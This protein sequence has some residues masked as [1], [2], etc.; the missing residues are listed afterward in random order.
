MIIPS[1]AIAQ[2]D[3][4]VSEIETVTVQETESREVRKAATILKHVASAFP[5]DDL[6]GK[7]VTRGEFVKY[8]AQAFCLDY[9]TTTSG[10]FADVDEKNEA[11]NE[12]NNALANGWISEA[13]RF[14]PNSAISFDEAIKITICAAN[15]EIA[16]NND[17]GFPYGYIRIAQRLKITQNIKRGI[18]DS[19]TA[20]D[21]ALIIYRALKT[22]DVISMS[23]GQKV[24]YRERENNYLYSLHG[25]TEISGTVTSTDVT[26]LY[27]GIDEA[28]EGYIEIDDV[29]YAF[30]GDATGLIGLECTVYY[31]EENK[32][33][34][35]VEAIVPEKVE[36][37]VVD[38]DDFIRSA[39]SEIYY[40]DND[41]EK[42]QIIN[43][44]I[45]N[46][47][48]IESFEQVK[49]ILENGEM[50]FVDT[51]GDGKSNLLFIENY[52]YM[53]VDNV[54]AVEM[55]VGDRN[56]KNNPLFLK[57][58]N[59]DLAIRYAINDE[60]SNEA[61]DIYDLAK[62]DII[63][64]KESLDGMRIEIVICNTGGVS[65]NVTAINPSK[66]TISI[67]G[68]AHK[69]TDYAIDNYKAELTVGVSGYFA[70]GIGGKIVA[71]NGEI[72]AYNYGYVLRAGRETSIDTTVR[73]KMFTL[74]GKIE[75]ME[76][77]KK[78]T[79]DGVSGKSVNEAYDGL[80]DKTQ[81]IKYS[82]NSKGQIIGIDFAEE[83]KPTVFEDEINPKNNLTQFV[84]S[85][86]TLLYRSEAKSFAPYFNATGSVVMKIPKDKTDELSFIVSDSTVLVNDRR[87]SKEEMSVY[88]LTEDG[89]AK[90]IVWEYDPASETLAQKDKSYIVAEISTAL[91]SEGDAVTL[92]DCWADGMYYKLYLP[93]NVVIEKDSGAGLC[94]GD[95]FRALLN[96]KNEILKIYVDV[97]TSND[98]VRANNKSGA[99]YYGGNVLVTY[100]LGKIYHWGNS[101]VYMSNTKDPFGGYDYSFSNLYNCNIGANMIKFDMKEKTLR[102]IT[103]DEIRS[104]V[105]Y[106]KDN[107]F[108]VLRQH[109]FKGSCVFIYE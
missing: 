85:P 25:I 84:F 38:I 39:G 76:L 79:I 40:Y 105:S 96:S 31:S 44:V 81:V 93:D 61:L 104:Y 94:Q 108:A 57:D 69:L 26:S 16:A 70:F 74:Q 51:N 6:Y 27:P 82:L 78:L 15:Y 41:K 101:Y 4:D 43:K 42:R 8:L 80:K 54:N 11:Y 12:I 64:V 58:E 103:A 59:K 19:I 53:V 29:R 68:A 60:D 109:R 97:D 100:Y 18:G 32:G 2:E 89:S 99:T 3:T 47:K 24:L 71:I 72:G 50:R 28:Q 5:T 7:T 20:A 56:R 102:P 86:S 83:N 77:A 73:V 36:E 87:Y 1:V 22:A 37:T 91:N 46:G 88:D 95:I 9:E 55:T 67:D 106:G 21:A 45:Y 17:G 10:V 62:D 13:E 90:L 23:D 92:I 35:K 14:N 48:S 75:S 98:H 33:L 30:D 107:H 34:R 52:R 66:K 63:A 49:N 65:G